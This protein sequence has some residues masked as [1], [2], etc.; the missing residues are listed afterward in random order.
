MSGFF[1]VSRERYEAVSD[2]I[3]PRGFK[4]LLEFL[5]RGPR[6]TVD[7]IGYR[8]GR[9]LHGS[10]KL[11]GSVVVAYLL[12][13][14]ELTAGRFVSARFTA[15][16]LVGATGVVIRVGADWFLTA[17]GVGWATAIAIELSILW[18]FQLNND[19]TFSSLGYRGRDRIR[20]LLLFHLVSAQGVLVQTSVTAL[21]SGAAV[22]SDI[23][24]S[25]VAAW[26]REALGP[27]LAGIVA[28]TVGNYLLNTTITWPTS[29][30]GRAG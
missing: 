21:L 6:P 5:A 30:R 24:S 9:R 28:A 23:L 4:I 25:E 22:A 12:A 2:R 16:A 10:T 20:P 1:A 17:A 27:V 8:F 11:T 19:F 7:E 14:I 26:R 18:N 15:Y 3:N 29:P 13:L